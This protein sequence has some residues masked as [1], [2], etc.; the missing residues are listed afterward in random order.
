MEGLHPEIL[1]QLKTLGFAVETFEVSR[2]KEATYWMTYTANWNWDMA[3]YLT[4]FQVTLLEEG[5]VLGRAEYDARKGGANMAK[6]G[7]TAEK[8]RP[9]LI[10]LLQQVQRSDATATSFGSGANQP[11]KPSPIDP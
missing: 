4:Y 2:P 11:P 9:L 7:K 8:I 1:Q 3:M 6:F 5:K 10:D